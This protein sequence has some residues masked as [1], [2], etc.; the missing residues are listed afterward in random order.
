MARMDTNRTNRR[1]FLKTASAGLAVIANAQQRPNA[2]ASQTGVV[3]FLYDR[4]TALD[5]IGPYEVR[6][7]TA[8]RPIRRQ[9]RPSFAHD[10]CC[11]TCTR[12][13]NQLRYHAY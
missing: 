9:R 13:D 10:R 4:M 12:Q 11:A 8:A 6:H 2:A 7:S 1:E 3:I 5:A